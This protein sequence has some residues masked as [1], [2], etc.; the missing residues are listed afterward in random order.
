MY[1][2]DSRVAFLVYDVTRSDSFKSMSRWMEDIIKN[3]PKNISKIIFKIVF[4]LVANKVDLINS[5]GKGTIS[6]EEG[7]KLAK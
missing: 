4:Y 2:R 6:F 3:S 5:D 7:V 1:Y